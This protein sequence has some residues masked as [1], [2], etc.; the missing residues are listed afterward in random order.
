MSTLVATVL[1][2]VILA[3]VVLVIYRSVRI[4]P[5][6]TAGIVERF[7]RYHRT[8][9]AGLNMVTPFV[10]RRRRGR[11]AGPAGRLGPAG[12]AGSAGARA[13]A[14]AEARTGRAVRDGPAVRPGH[15]S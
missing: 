6:A 13:E 12:A 4:I 2:V 8:L 3:V 7:G 9:N 5:Q 10:D 11:G 15:R 1:L 14:G